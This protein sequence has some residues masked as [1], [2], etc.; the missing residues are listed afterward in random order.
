VNP[1]PKHGIKRKNKKLKNGILNKP[2]NEKQEHSPPPQGRFITPIL[3]EY[4]P[5]ILELDVFG[6]G[7]HESP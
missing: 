2:R 3:P 5:E 4:N 7:S 1:A 6:R